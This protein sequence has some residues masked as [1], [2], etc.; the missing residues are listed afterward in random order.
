MYNQFTFIYNLFIFLH[1]LFLIVSFIYLF[2]EITTGSQHADLHHD[3]VVCY[4]L[5]RLALLDIN[6]F[7][8]LIIYNSIYLHIIKLSMQYIY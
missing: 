4:C 1:S 2:S 3:N 8:C 7:I 5:K 6:H